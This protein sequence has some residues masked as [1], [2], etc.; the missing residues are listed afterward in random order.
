MSKQAK[1]SSRVVYAP[2]LGNVRSARCDPGERAKRKDGSASKAVFCDLCWRS[3]EFVVANTTPQIYARRS[4][5]VYKRVEPTPEMR[6]KAATEATELTERYKAALRGSEGRYAAPR[7]LADHCDIAELRGDFSA[8]SFHEHVEQSILWRLMAQTGDVLGDTACPG[9]DGTLVKPS[10]KYCE[11][12]NPR[13]SLTARRQYQRDRKY[14]DEFEL[15]VLDVAAEHSG[16]FR[17]WHIDDRSRIRRL[18]YERVRGIPTVDLVRELEEQGTCSRAD[19]AKRL[20]ISRQAVYAAI[21]SGSAGRKPRRAT[22]FGTH[23]VE[24]H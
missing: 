14:Q 5:H 17:M 15:A 23:L 8:E 18:A 10:K 3:T 1:N 21:N 7:L 19:I 6:A 16:E 4:R 9:L 24:S 22:T 11:Q 12:H 2:G 13:R 20:G